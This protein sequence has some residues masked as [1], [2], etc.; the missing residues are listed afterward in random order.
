MKRFWFYLQRFLPVFVYRLD[1]DYYDNTATCVGYFVFTGLR[2]C[3]VPVDQYTM[4]TENVGWVVDLS[5]TFGDHLCSQELQG[6][7]ARKI[8]ASMPKHIAEGC[9]F[10]FRLRLNRNPE[11]VEG[12]S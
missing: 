5:K 1:A 12:A 11:T 10:L 8:R 2:P 9:N 6:R 3:F 4:A 7:V